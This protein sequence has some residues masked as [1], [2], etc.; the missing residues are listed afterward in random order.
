MYSWN[1]FPKWDNLL[2]GMQVSF[3]R[4]FILSACCLMHGKYSA[5]SEVFSSAPGI[6]F[7]NGLED[8]EMIS[9]N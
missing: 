4:R 6:S 2:Q 8:T 1:V 3:I 5:S 9:S 7:P